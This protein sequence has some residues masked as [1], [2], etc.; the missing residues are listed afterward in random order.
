MNPVM[1]LA[2]I[3]VAGTAAF[4]LSSAALAQQTGTKSGTVATEA[5]PAD[6]LQNGTVTQ[7]NRLKGTMSIQQTP[8]G[9]VGAAGAAV[10]EFKTQN[11][12]ML[13]SVHA[14]DKVG[15]AVSGSDGA[16]TITRIEKR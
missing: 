8:N 15:Y 10:E 14:G 9:T 11:G 13:D 6:G 7:I 12:A 16:K 3:L 1:K 4:S 2:S 5:T